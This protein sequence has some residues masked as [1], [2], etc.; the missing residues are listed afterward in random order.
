MVVLFRKSELAKHIAEKDK[1]QR[2]TKQH[3]QNVSENEFEG[4]CNDAIIA[5]EKMLDEYQVNL[6]PYGFDGKLIFTD[7]QR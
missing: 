4:R 1:K 2:K 7:V 3:Y 5:L 6:H